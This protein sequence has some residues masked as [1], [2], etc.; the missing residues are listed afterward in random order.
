MISNI[1]HAILNKN[2]NLNTLL[3]A[4]DQVHGVAMNSQNDFIAW[5]K[6]SHLTWS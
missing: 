5:L 4:H 1:Y 6:G 2:F 3:F